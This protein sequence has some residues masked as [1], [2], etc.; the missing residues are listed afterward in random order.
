MAAGLADCS[1]VQSVRSTKL[2]CLASS[3]LGSDGISTHVMESLQ[4]QAN[5]KIY[6]FLRSLCPCSQCYFYLQPPLL[7]TL[8]L[9][10]TTSATLVLTLVLCSVPV[11]R[12]T[13]GQARPGWCLPVSPDPPHAPVPC[14]LE[15]HHMFEN[16]T[17]PT[18]KYKVRNTNINFNHFLVQFMS[19]SQ[20]CTFNLCCH[21]FCCNSLQ[22]FVRYQN[23][24][25]TRLAF[26]WNFLFRSSYKFSFTLHSNGSLKYRDQ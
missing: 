10:S 23:K 19:F 16:I 25:I 18:L 3:V 7:L 26:I 11:V 8:V 20:C 12:R 15:H 14:S 6:L 13:A 2:R 1:S 4:F 24:C 22:M 21:F 17:R 9:V 5:N